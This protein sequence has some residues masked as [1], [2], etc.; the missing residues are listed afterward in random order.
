MAT[1]YQVRYVHLNNVK[2]LHWIE[3]AEKHRR[4]LLCPKDP[5][6]KLCYLVFNLENH[7]DE[8]AFQVR[9]KVN[10]AWNRWK[11]AARLSV[12]DPPEVK[13]NCCIVPPPYHVDHINT[14]GEFLLV[15]NYTRRLCVFIYDDLQAHFGR[16]RSRRLQQRKM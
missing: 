3:E 2:H 6:S 8:Y 7:P 11:T 14:P 1:H 13:E 15:N 5:C 9:A 10:G 12:A 16:C 4:D